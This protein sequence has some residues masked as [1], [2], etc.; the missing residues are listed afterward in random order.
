MVH[1]LPKEKKCFVKLYG[2]SEQ[3]VHFSD[4]ILN[5]ALRNG[6]EITQ[7]VYSSK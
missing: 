6:E 5:D 7:K 2:K 1:T 4:K 3:E